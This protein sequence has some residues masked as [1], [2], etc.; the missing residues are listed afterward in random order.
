MFG[1]MK[2]IR[3]LYQPTVGLLGCTQPWSLVAPSPGRVVTGEMSPREA[4][5]AADWL[6]VG[7][8]IA[9]HY[10]DPDHPHVLA[11]LEE[12]AKR[13]STGQR[14][15]LAMKPGECIDIVGAEFE[16]AR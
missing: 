2:L 4:A 5:I 13:D 12:A 11:F 9:C 10:E 16:M 6:G 15:V 1:D 8:A 7:L 14:K 3:E